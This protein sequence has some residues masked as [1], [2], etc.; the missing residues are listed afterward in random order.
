FT[1]RVFPPL[2][3]TP[4]FDP[5]YLKSYELGMKTEWLEHRLRLNVAGVYSDY[6]G[7]QLLV[8]QGIAPTVQN[9]GQAV[10]KGIEVEVETALTD[11]L[12]VSG[13][14]G[15]TDAYYRSVSAGAA[16]PRGANNHGILITDELPNAAKWTVTSG[17]SLDVLQN[18][19]GR[20]TL[21]GDY[22][23]KSGHYLD[24]I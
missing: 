24:A 8:N 11:R 9:A 13:G 4:S 16:T 2:P 10:I 15:Y 7:I 22:F 3:Q 12:R 6:S 1:Q 14:T 17:V 5:E 20:L 18:S 23:Y 19:Q 21:R